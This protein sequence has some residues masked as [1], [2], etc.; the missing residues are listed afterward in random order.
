MSLTVKPLMSLGGVGVISVV[1]NEIPGEIA[2]L[3]DFCLK[4]DFESA[5]EIH[6][7]YSAL[8]EVNFVESNPGPVKAAL[9][10][11][12]LMEMNYRLPMV[13]P[14]SENLRKIREVLKV[15]G[16]KYQ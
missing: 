14:R 9:S 1:S 2:T 8:M 4:G 15:A 12:G 16:L 10:M 11:M 6:R 5:R 7:R 13:P 3:C